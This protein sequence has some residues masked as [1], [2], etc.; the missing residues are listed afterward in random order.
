[1][2]MRV[3]TSEERQNLQGNTDFIEKAEWA[4]R[5]YASYWSMHDGGG[6]DANGRIKWA[7]DRLNSV[8]IVLND[9]NDSSLGLKFMKL[10]KGVQVDLGAAPVDPEVI[11][12]AFEAANKFEEIAS[13]YFDQLGETINFSTTGN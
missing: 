7:K 9:I 4:V 1:M 10:G 11:I 8:N 3:L 13:L 6:L 5:D 12:A 2:A